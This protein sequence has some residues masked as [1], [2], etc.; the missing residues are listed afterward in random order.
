MNQMKYQFL[1][2]SCIGILIN[3][4][5]ASASFSLLMNEEENQKMQQQIALKSKDEAFK[6]SL[7]DL[8]EKEWL[9]ETDL[10]NSLEKYNQSDSD[11][12]E[13]VS[14]TLSTLAKFYTSKNKPEL[15]DRKYDEKVALDFNQIINN[16]SATLLSFFKELTEKDLL[17]SAFL[18]KIRN[19]LQ[20][21]SRDI[22]SKIDLASLEEL[23]PELKTAYKELDKHTAKKRKEYGLEPVEIYDEVIEEIVKDNGERPAKRQKL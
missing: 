4:N 7:L 23:K 18:D 9:Y 2:L 15:A 10:L 19:L 8:K 5:I 12:P 13:Y 3:T 6:S 14:R 20:N 21:Q 17:A 22:E 16:K 11:D 1:T